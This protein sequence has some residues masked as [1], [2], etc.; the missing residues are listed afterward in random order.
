[1]LTIKSNGLDK[2]IQILDALPTDLEAKAQE[3]IKRLAQFG[4]E[5]A[6]YYYDTAQYAGG[7]DK[8][9]VS[10]TEEGKGVV[11]VTAE[12][13]AVLYI[14]FGT[15]VKYPDDLEA[16]ADIISGDV[17]GRGQHGK[18]HGASQ[19]GWYY[20]KEH[21]IGNNPPPDTE[22]ATKP[23]MEMFYHTYGNPSEAATYKA[24]KEL[25]EKAEQIAREVFGNDR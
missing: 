7:D 12:G 23:G 22:D 16:R 5:R 15:G 4:V 3:F 19:K 8:V 11:R 10:F 13:H 1:M 18:R 17:D 9:S 21:G 20:L 2:A 14:E 25:C 6:Q 24:K